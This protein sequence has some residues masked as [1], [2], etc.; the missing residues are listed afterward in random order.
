MCGAA[1][2]SA[3]PNAETKT[4]PSAKVSIDVP[5]GWKMSSKGD[6]M[7]VTD[8]TQEVGFILL[9]S[10][11]ND[12]QKAI[13]ALD[14]EVGKV[15]KDIRWASK[16]PSPTKLNGMDAL[17]NEGSAVIEGKPAAIAV[18]LVKTPANKYLLV[19]G[20]VDAAKKA[21]HDAELEHFVTSIKPAR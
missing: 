18:V 20:A 5:S 1:S 11:G 3:R 8:P 7:T 13:A 21:A 17:E 9:V 4:H 14:A 16:E 12:L 15:A 6:V 19:L 2:G 10:D